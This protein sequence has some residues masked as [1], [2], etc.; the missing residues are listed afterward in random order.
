MSS[1]TAQEPLI[2]GM[3][4]CLEHTSLAQEPLFDCLVE[5]ITMLFSA[6]SREELRYM[7]LRQAPTALALQLSTLLHTIAPG[8]VTW[9]PSMLNAL[10]AY[11]PACT[12][13]SVYGQGPRWLYCALAAYAGQE[14]FYQF[15]PHVLT[16]CGKCRLGG[17]SSSS[18]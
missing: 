5:R 11:I 6:Y 7:H 13:L 4:A 3:F 17:F 12:P 9:E 1:I 16:S 14:A 15:D 8:S 18:P 10:F 2:T